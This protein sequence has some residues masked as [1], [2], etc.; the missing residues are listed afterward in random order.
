MLIQLQTILHKQGNAH[1]H[2]LFVFSFKMPVLPI[3]TFKW[4]PHCVRTVRCWPC[5]S[6]RAQG[7][8]WAELQYSLSHHKAQLQGGIC[9]HS[10]IGEQARQVQG[11]PRPKRHK[12]LQAL[13]HTHTL[14]VTQ[15]TNCYVQVLTCLICE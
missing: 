15:S 7:R 11:L 8:V 3:Q 10:T 2:A 5:K 6:D 12:D 4:P 1:M 9:R 13:G 14:S